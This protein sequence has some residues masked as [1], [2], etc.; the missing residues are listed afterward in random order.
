MIHIDNAAAVRRGEIEAAREHAARVRYAAGHLNAGE[1][2]PIPQTIEQFSAMD[3]TERCNLQRTYP[4]VYQVWSD[5]ESRQQG[6][7]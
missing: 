3:Y 7:Q 2:P 4:S 6:R 1:A 5:L